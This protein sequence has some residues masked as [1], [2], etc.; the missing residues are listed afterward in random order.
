MWKFE[1]TWK[2]KCESEYERCENSDECKCELDTEP[3]HRYKSQRS[4]K[5][6][7]KNSGTTENEKSEIA[8]VKIEMTEVWKV[9]MWKSE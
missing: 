9:Y 2:C 5:C 8:N 6:E 4:V 1:M 3:R 7:C